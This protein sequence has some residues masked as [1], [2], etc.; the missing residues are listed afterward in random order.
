MRY[1]CAQSQHARDHNSLGRIIHDCS[2]LWQR[3]KLLFRIAGFIGT[4]LFLRLAFCDFCPLNRLRT[5]SFCFCRFGYHL[6]TTHKSQN[7]KKKKKK[8]KKKGQLR[9]QSTKATKP[10]VMKTIV[11]KRLLACVVMFVT[12]RF[13][14]NLQRC[15]FESCFLRSFC[16]S[17]L[18]PLQWN[19]FGLPWRKLDSGQ[20]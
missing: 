9:L 4:K 15:S 11:V 2:I 10:P 5:H 16:L 3:R 14:M 19:I 18:A 6:I 20:V 7:S 13:T 17:F 1:L 12:N 8:R